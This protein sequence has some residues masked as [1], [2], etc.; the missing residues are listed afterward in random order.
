MKKNC[1]LSLLLI[2][3]LMIGLVAYSNGKTSRTSANPNQNSSTST[4]VSQADITAAAEIGDAFVDGPKIEIMLGYSGSD[5]TLMGKKTYVM[6]DRINE[7]SGGKITVTVYPNGQLGGDTELFEGVQSGNVTMM[8]ST[9]SSQVNYIPELAILDIGGL[10]T[11]LDSCNAVLR[12]KYFDIINGYYRAKGLKLLSADATNFRVMSSNK[13]INTFSDYSGVKIR[14]QENRYHT[15]YWSALGANPTPLTFGELYIGLQQGLVEAQENPAEVLQASKF[16]EVQDYVVMTNHIPFVSMIIM[17]LD[18][19][20]SLP[21]AYQEVL[22]KNIRETQNELIAESTENELRVLS[23]LEADGMTV[24]RLDD[25]T[26]E[27]MQAGTEACITEM[28]K[29]LSA[30][31]VDAY[32]N[33][34]RSVK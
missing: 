12:G 11:D 6:A 2:L 26:L 28:K 13:P 23:E 10:Y 8:V 20:N 29:K 3:T 14:T 1:L 4:N 30:D 32:V 22:S 15:T 18:F 31:V 17:N 19:W 5:E 33:A 27:Q 24:I 21:E 16:Q 25:K 34:A 7:A 9:P